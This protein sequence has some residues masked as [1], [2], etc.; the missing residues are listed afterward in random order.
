[1]VH[2]DLKPANVLINSEGRVKVC[3]CWVLEISCL[4]FTVLGEW[5]TMLLHRVLV[6]LL[7]PLRLYTNDASGDRLW[8]VKGAGQH[9][10]QGQ[11]VPRH[12]FVH[13]TRTDRHADGWS[14]GPLLMLL[15]W[16]VV[17]VVVV[18]FVVVVAMAVN[19]FHL[20]PLFKKPFP[21]PPRPFCFPSFLLALWSIGSCVCASPLTTRSRFPLFAQSQRMA[22]RMGSTFGRL[23]FF[24]PSATSAHTRILGRW[25]RRRLSTGTPSANT[26]WFTGARF[27]CRCDLPCPATATALQH[28]GGDLILLRARG[29]DITPAY[30]AHHNPAT[31]RS[32]D[33]LL[34]QYRVEQTEEEIAASRRYHVSHVRSPSS[35]HYCLLVNVCVSAFWCALQPRARVL[36]DP[37]LCSPCIVRVFVR[38]AWNM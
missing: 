28:P 6:D 8:G 30:E 19:G 36:A 9:A 17:V 35:P 20:S 34:E 25:W 11:D 27:V 23:V 37:L 15:L 33:A 10:C 18:V 7:V 26:V 38:P 4:A 13:G 24:W 14:V 32:R 21:S 12:L 2:R 31:Q 1:M 5:R 3:R 16:V 29:L 22:T